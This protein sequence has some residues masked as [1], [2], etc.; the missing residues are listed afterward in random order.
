MTH[1]CEQAH[2]PCATHCRAAASKLHTSLYHFLFSFLSVTGALPTAH[3]V[4]FTPMSFLK[5]AQP[6][7]FRFRQTSEC[8]NASERRVLNPKQYAKPK[9]DTA[10]VL[11]QK[12]PSNRV[13]AQPAFEKGGRKLLFLF[14]GYSANSSSSFTFLA[15]NLDI[16]SALSGLCAINARS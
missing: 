5:K 4:L 6:K 15:I 12:V 16:C 14:F 9:R 3:F 13:Q 2:L 11:S 7:T 8:D 10:L 1:H